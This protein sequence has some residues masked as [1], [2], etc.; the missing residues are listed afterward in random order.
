MSI[1]PLPRV[2][3]LIWCALALLFGQSV[4][5]GQPQTLQT[6]VS[7]PVTEN[8]AGITRASEAALGLTRKLP[9]AYVDACVEILRE[10]QVNACP[11]LVPEGAMEVRSEGASL[12]VM[13]GIL[14]AIDGHDVDA[15]GGH[16]TIWVVKNRGGR[17]MLAD[18]MHATGAKIPSQCR[19]L[20]LEG[21]RVEACRVPPYPDGGYYGN[22]IA[23]GWQRGDRVYNIS[24]H[25]H[26][27]EPRLR[28]MVAAL[29][30]QQ[31]QPPPA[32]AR[33]DAA[34]ITRCDAGS[35]TTPQPVSVAR[36][37]DAISPGRVVLTCRTVESLAATAYVQY[38]DA[39]VHPRWAVGMRGTQVA[40]G[41][42]WLRTETYTVEA[43]AP[44]TANGPMMLGPML[45][46]LLEDRFKLKVH[47]AHRDVPVYELTRT[48]DW[49]SRL[50][51]LG[52]KEGSC[53]PL[54][55]LQDF[56]TIA[57]GQRWC[58]STITSGATRS[59]LD[60]QAATLGDLT[61][62]LTSQ[63]FVGRRV[64]DRVGYPGRYDFHLE[65]ASATGNVSPETV[66]ES[67]FAAIRERLGMTIESATGDAE[68]LVIDRAER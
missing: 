65:F 2:P 35:E 7:R 8:A 64:T 48:N 27:N 54:E 46:T 44:V 10:M 3:T 24:M 16:W 19:F 13:S 52:F 53:V 50:R 62:L 39:L 1:P 47:R 21:Q 32:R 43:A 58:S 14:G 55:P 49:Y 61:I 67:L 45:Q 6:P 12:D 68:F 59:R 26:A 23:Y 11:P 36:V 30:E 40:G 4:A 57:P 28:V 51:A 38:A 37:G 20:R 9:S 66:R 22:H 42:S 29:L 34:S 25:N 15:H 31:R 17:Q 63:P 33:F 56:D 18:H 60:M 5:L 41:P